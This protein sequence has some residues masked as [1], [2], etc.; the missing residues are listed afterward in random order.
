M[1]CSIPC[2]TA[3]SQHSGEVDIGVHQNRS[4][5]N[6][7]VSAINCQAGLDLL[8]ADLPICTRIFYGKNSDYL[9]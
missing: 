5:L 2:M 3:S 4:A 7:T 6:S 8:T 9:Q 1:L